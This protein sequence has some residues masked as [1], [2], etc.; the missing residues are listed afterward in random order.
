MPALP[1]P[2]KVIKCRFQYTDGSDANILNTVH[3]S[4]TGTVSSADLTTI[5]G[6]L[7]TAFGSDMKSYMVSRLTLANI[8][9]TDLSSDT[10]AEVETPIN[11]AGTNTGMDLPSS[12]CI[13]LKGIIARRYRGGHPRIYWTGLPSNDLSS[14]NVWSTTAAGNLV[15]AWESVLAAFTSAPPSDL[16]TVAQV[17]VSYYNGFTVVTSPTTGRTRN[18]PKL[19]ETP[20]VDVITSW[21]YNPKIAAQRRRNEQRS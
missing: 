17:N 2:G 9:L 12:T 20:V 1:S 15:S 19:R 8:T 7:G 16:G 21:G 13:V 18:V 5:A 6:S 4:Y 10:G 11:I 3:F 14:P